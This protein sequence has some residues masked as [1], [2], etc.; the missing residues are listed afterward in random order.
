MVR[1]HL[2]ATAAGWTLASDALLGRAEQCGLLQPIGLA[3]C[4][5][6]VAGFQ[7]LVSANDCLAPHLA[8]WGTGVVD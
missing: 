5:V 4:V 2:I 7:Q 6:Q 8:C 3:H 1:L